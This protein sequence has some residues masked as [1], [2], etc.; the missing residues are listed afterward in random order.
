[1]Y[2]DPVTDAVLEE[3]ADSVAKAMTPKPGGR[4]PKRNWI[5]NT[6]PDGKGH[7]P[8]YV[9][10]IYQAIEK[11][12]VP[13]SK[14]IQI[15]LGKVEK[16]SKGIGNVDAGTR[17][18]AR[19]AWAQ[20]QAL[21]AKNRALAEA[22]RPVAL[23]E[24]E[25]L[26]A[27]DAITELLVEAA[28]KR[29]HGGALFGMGNAVYDVAKMHELA[30]GKPTVEVDPGQFAH[31]FGEVR[32]DHQYA[33]K[34]NLGKPVLLAAR[35]GGGSALVD[36]WHRAY[37]GH[38]QRKK[39]RGHVLSAQELESCRVTE[40]RRADDGIVVPEPGDRVR[41]LPAGR[42]GAA[43][44]ADNL[45]VDV[46]CDDGRT[47]NVPVDQLVAEAARGSADPGPFA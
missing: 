6:E 15:A 27:A 24:A 3:A 38:A 5:E 40:A 11:R 29:R 17:A 25:Q 43:G 14:A 36:G 1:M 12:G 45:S 42:R 30:Q 44:Q 10:H 28:A 32:I 33:L 26:A 8:P 18:A 21:K 46:H 4:S 31:A 39:L 7:L 34:T 20:W 47:V 23:A 9:Q 13:R 35:P 2:A 37:K 16:W 41:I 19:I 22:E